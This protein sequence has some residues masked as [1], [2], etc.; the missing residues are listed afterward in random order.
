M[1]MQRLVATMLLTTGISL[2]VPAFAQGIEKPPV[3]SIA[4]ID[5]DKIMRGSMAVKSARTQIDEIA[6]NLQEQ[7]A[8]EEETLRS[9]EQ[10]LQQQ[11][12]LLTPDVYT[13][14][15]QRLQARAAT[16]QQRA[17]SLRQTLDRGMAQ[18]MQRIQLVLFDEV[19]KLAEEIGVNLVLPR[20]QI[21]VAFDSFDISDKALKRLN[22]RLSEIE[23][24]MQQEEPGS[25]APR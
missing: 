21:V 22:E 23:I 2:T 24:S 9:E 19:G 10:Q 15:R 1:R 7:I 8:T 13:D 20:S 4:I 25:P 5:V 17:R 3:P 16:L 6:G 11:R 18:T 12:A 14:R